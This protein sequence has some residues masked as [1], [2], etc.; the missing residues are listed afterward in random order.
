MGFF[1]HIGNPVATLTVDATTLVVDSTNDRVGIG[2]T[3]PART[4]HV[5]RDAAARSAGPLLYALNQPV[6]IEDDNRPGI[7]LIGSENNIGVIEFGDE[8][9]ANAG[10]IN[11]DHSTDRLR[12]GFGDDAEKVYIDS[13]GNMI[14]GGNL[15]ISSG[16]SGTPS[17]DAGI[18]IERGSSTNAAMIWDESRDE[19]V[20]CTTTATG[21]ATGDLTFTPANLSVER[22]GAGTEQAEAEVHAKRDTSSGGQYSTTASVIA[23]DDARP[24]VQLVG[25]ANNIGMLQF[26]DNAA[27]DSG[28]IYYDH[29]TNKLRIDTNGTENVV[30][31]SSGKVGIGATSPAKNLEVRGATPFI[32]ITDTTD[33]TWDHGDIFGGIECYTEDTHGPDGN[34]EAVS[35]YIKF[36]HLRATSG[37]GYADS[38]LLFGTTSGSAP[39]TTSMVLDNAGQLGIGTTTPNCALHVAGA[40]AFS[41]PSETFI[42][43][44]SSDTTPSVATGNLFKTHASGQTLTMFDDGVAGQNITVISTAAVVFDVTSTNLKGG[45]TDITT[46]SGDITTWSFDGTN[47]YLQQFMDVSAD[48]STVGGATAATSAAAAGTGF[49]AQGAV[50]TTKVINE[51]GTFVTRLWVDLGLAEALGKAL[52]SRDSAYAVIGDSTGTSHD[53]N[54]YL[55]S[56]TSATAGIITGCTVHVLETPA[57]GSTK[58]GVAVSATQ[59]K[60]TGDLLSGGH[61]SL[62]YGA[63]ATV[64]GNTF[65][66]TNTGIAGSSTIGFTQGTGTYYVYL[67]YAG[68]GSG[69]TYTKYTAGKL[70]I[71]ITGIEDLAV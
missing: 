14:V 65:Q 46:A 1:H 4:L 16:T 64:I 11:F 47:W 15:E 23:E 8:S 44:D 71:E 49:D 17:G 25:S 32:R 30:I 22:I 10:S 3:S 38:G 68:S 40:A 43:F 20:F 45:S 69:S 36:A 13:S 28:Q 35:A 27:A 42:T 39:A 9:H 54:A 67:F 53:A 52:Y 60:A 31:D 51:N 41:G 12:F 21:A 50:K 57:G 70:M 2:T 7:Q 26:G 58:L 59:T 5:V 6:I 61:L 18:I 37:H 24:A 56:F 48:M 63:A 34:G 29:S 33:G 55:T 19:F 66:N 62:V